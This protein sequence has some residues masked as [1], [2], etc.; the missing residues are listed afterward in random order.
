MFNGHLLAADIDD[1]RPVIDDGPEVV[2]MP[3]VTP[4]GSANLQS[5]ENALHADG[6]V[7]GSDEEV[8]VTYE[9]DPS[10]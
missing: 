3:T 8:I 9:D 2:E 7:I 5:V 1:S 10:R 6:H 4:A